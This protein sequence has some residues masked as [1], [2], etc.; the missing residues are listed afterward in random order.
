MNIFEIPF[1]AEIIFAISTLVFFFTIYAVLPGFIYEKRTMYNPFLI[2]RLWSKIIQ[3]AKS[4]FMNLF[5]IS[6]EKELI[7]AHIKVQNGPYKMNLK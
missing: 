3:E 6:T 2:N 7:E 5:T 1:L 4:W